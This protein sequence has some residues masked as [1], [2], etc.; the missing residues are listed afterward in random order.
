MKV[1][2][3]RVLVEKEEEQGS[4]VMERWMQERF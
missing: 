1:G 2:T 3:G 4:K